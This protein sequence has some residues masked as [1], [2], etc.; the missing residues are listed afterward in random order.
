MIQPARSSIAISLITALLVLFAVSSAFAGEVIGTVTHL[1][2][3]LFAQKSDGSRKVLS[4]KSTVEEGDILITEKQTYARVKFTDK[5]EITLRPNS[6]LKIDQYAFDE[7]KPEKDKA[8]FNISKGGLR[9]MTGAI[10]KRGNQDSYKMST[11]NAVVGVRGT[12]YEIKLCNN[13]CGSLAN[14]LYMFVPEGSIA[15]STTTGTQNVNAGQYVYVQSPTSKPVI[16]PGPPA[17][18]DF[19]LPPSVAPKSDNGKSS[20]GGTESKKVECTVR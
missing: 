2:G 13:N 19:K 4:Q 7:A 3:P 12:I 8:V 1:S 10:G 11:P 17:G 9:S 5:G 15:V 14:G 16:L 18:I 6:Q 20:S